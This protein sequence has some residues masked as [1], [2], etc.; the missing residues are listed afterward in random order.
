MIRQLR[1][2]FVVVVG[3]IVLGA[4]AAWLL[5]RLSAPAP[6]SLEEVFLGVRVGMSWSEASDLLLVADTDI[7]RVYLS[8]VTYDGHTITSGIRGFQDLPPTRDIRVCQVEMVD[9]TGQGFIIELGDRGVVRR[10][11]FNLDVRCNLLTEWL[12]R[13]LL[14]QDAK[15]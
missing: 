8:G 4:S 11:R 15:S 5:W 9:S 10:K 14:R 13:L 3:L 1:R 2:S 6:G 12:V 7:D